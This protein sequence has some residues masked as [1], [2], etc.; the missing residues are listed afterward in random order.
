MT[1]LLFTL[2]LVLIFPLVVMGWRAMLLAL[3]LQGL[4]MGWMVAQR[5]PLEPDSAIPLLDL[6]IIRG[7]VVPLMLQRVMR[8]RAIGGRQ[9]VRAP[10]LFSLMVLALVIGAAFR[11]AAFV[12]PIGGESQVRL[13]VATCGLLLG[14]FLL[15]TQGGVFAQVV[16]V[17]YIENAI[18]LFEFDRAAGV[19]PLPVEL[20]LLAVFMMSASVYVA[21]V[22]RLS[23]FV[24]TIPI[25]LP[26]EG[27]TV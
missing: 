12:D 1:A 16:G 17:L 20:G 5:T 3:S 15:A 11:F 25:D 2:L 8:D 21:Y 9:D 7:A 14:L 10:N 26:D 22:E 13:A 18:A 27:P 4:L 6:L 19:L 24:A 23:T